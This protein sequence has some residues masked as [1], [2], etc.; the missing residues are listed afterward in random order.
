MKTFLIVSAV[1]LF[2]LW[3]PLV[4]RVRYAEKLTVYAG[5][6]SPFARIYPFSSRSEKK[7]KEKKETGGKVALREQWDWIFDLIKRFPG[8]LHRLIRIRKLEFKAV[9]GDEDPG[10][11]AIRYGRINAAIGSLAPVL[12][13]IYPIEKWDVAVRTDFELT[14]S[15]YQGEFRC[16]TNLWRIIRVLI[17]VLYHSIMIKSDK[18]EILN[19]GK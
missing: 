11:L 16:N 8:Y 3:M 19:H 6:F 15:V 9:V 7:K 1:I 17:S 4:L 2:L 12:N 13:P 14:E 10:D 18:K 5:I